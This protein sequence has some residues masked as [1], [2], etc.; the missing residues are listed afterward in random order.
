MANL[1]AHWEGMSNRS[2]A[3]EG[4]IH[5]S[6]NGRSHVLSVLLDAHMYRRAFFQDIH[7]DLGNPGAQR[8]N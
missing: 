1:A 6:A 7:F 5:F 8:D 4:W 2:R 3:C